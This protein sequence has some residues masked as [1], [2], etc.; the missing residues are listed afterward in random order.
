M[1]VFRAVQG[2]ILA[3]PKGK[4]PLVVHEGDID[5]MDYDGKRHLFTADDRIVKGRTHL[6][7]LVDGSVEQATAVPGEKRSVKLMTKEK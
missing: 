3:A 2:F 1:A 4:M 7:V 6:F 5:Y